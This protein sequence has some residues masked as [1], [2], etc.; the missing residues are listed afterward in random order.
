[1]VDDGEQKRARVISEIQKNL[2]GLEVDIVESFD[3]ESTLE[4]LS[5]DF[6]DL[7]ILDLV[8]PAADGDP[9]EQS[10]RSIIGQIMRGGKLNPPT[11]IIGLTQYENI[12]EDARKFYERNLFALEFYSSEKSDWAERISNKIRYLNKSKRAAVIFQANTFGLDMVVLV[13]RH[14]NE[15]LPVKKRLFSS[16]H[17]EEHPLWK[18]GIV[19]GEVNCAGRAPLNVALICVGEMGMTATAAVTSQAIALFRPKLISMVG[20]CCGFSIPESANPCKLMD[21]IV[22]RQ[23]SCWEEGRYQKSGSTLHN[24]G[25]EKV[26]DLDALEHEASEFRNRAKPRL[27]D[28]LIRDRVDRA[29][30]RS[31]DTLDPHLKKFA[32]QSKYKQVVEKFGEQVRPV[33]TVRFANIVSGSSVIADEAMVKEICSR[34]PSAIGLD[35]EIFGLYAA[36]ERSFGRRPS[37]IAIKGVADFGHSEKHDFGQAVASTISVDVLKHLLPH[38]GIF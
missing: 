8:L 33:P 30:E 6:F 24:G 11:H 17:A 12:G 14:K 23:V 32:G 26:T 31:S 34:H 36:A 16:I 4:K 35:M 2:I 3:Y 19:F 10:S 38:M 20:M 37:V 1:M 18:D 13:A 29:I 22:V 9:S 15:F 5:S 28:D 7:I 21:A 25:V 27:V